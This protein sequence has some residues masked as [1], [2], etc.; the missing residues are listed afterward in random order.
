MLTLTGSATHRFCDRLSRR[1]F[2]RIGAFGGPLV[3]PLVQVVKALK[4]WCVSLGELPRQGG[5]V[6][7]NLFAEILQRLQRF[8]PRRGEQCQRVKTRNRLN[9]TANFA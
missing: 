9:F 5:T 1:N 6:F 7:E 8:R 2:V 4:K 3:L